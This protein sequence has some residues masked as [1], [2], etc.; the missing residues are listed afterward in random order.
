MTTT[1]DREKLLDYYT[2]LLLF[3]AEGFQPLCRGEYIDYG[4]RE[5]IRSYLEEFLEKCH[6][7]D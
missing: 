5:L 3:M 2:G 4:Q 1:N 6:D 7:A